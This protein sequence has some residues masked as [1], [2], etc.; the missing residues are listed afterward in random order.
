[1]QT[2]EALS[3]K[4][5]ITRNGTLCRTVTTKCPRVN[6]N[7]RVRCIILDKNGKDGDVFFV[8]RNGKHKLNENYDLVEMVK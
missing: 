4:R 1:M 8:E 2:V 5:F 7:T 3:F 6:G